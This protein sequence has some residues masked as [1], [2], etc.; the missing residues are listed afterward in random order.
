MAKFLFCFFSQHHSHTFD[1]KGYGRGGDQ[2]GSVKLRC[3]VLLYHV[4]SLSSHMGMSS[5]E[6]LTA[7]NDHATMKWDDRQ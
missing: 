4:F 3:I 2:V 1:V 6:I 5:L 7:S